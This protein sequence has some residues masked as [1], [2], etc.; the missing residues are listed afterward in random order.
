MNA[1][2]SRDWVKTKH[3]HLYRRKSGIYYVRLGRNAWRSLK[4]KTIAVALHERDRILKADRSRLELSPEQRKVTDCSMAEMLI[5]RKRQIAEDITLKDST[6]QYWN[7]IHACLLNSWPGLLKRDVRKI[8]VEECQSWAAKYAETSSPS[9]FNNTVIALKRLFEIAIDLGLRYANPAGKIKKKPRVDKDL[10]LQL[11]SNEQ[12]KQFVA[13]I[14]RSPSRWAE[15]CGDLVEFLAY[16]GLRI[17]EAKWVTWQHC[18]FEKSRMLVTGNPES[19]T[20]NRKQRW[21]PMIPAL[22]ALLLKIREQR[23]PQATDPVMLVTSATKAMS[24]AAKIVGMSRITHHD[25]RHLYATICIEAGTDI[26]TVARWLG[27]LD[28][29]I[30]AMKTYGHLRDEHSVAMAERILFSA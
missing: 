25:L 12:F 10:T 30:L 28:G 15:A 20:K 3:E 8:S 9:H 23:K 13:E 24:R 17:G 27:H 5:R 21:V 18:N 29:G 16:S 14:R 6:K 26:P 19:A 7:D 2:K 1:N 22:K 11:P 4:T